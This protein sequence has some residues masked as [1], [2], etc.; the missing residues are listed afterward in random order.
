MDENNQNDKT[1]LTLKLL[2]IG[3]SR[4]GKTSLL[5]NYVEKIFPEAHISTLGV[6]YKEKEIIKDNYVI[7]LQIWDTAGEERF[8]SITK[9]IYRNANGILFVCDITNRE[10]FKNI[11]NWIKDADNVD[12]DIKGIIIGNKIDLDNERVVSVEDLE[13][14]EKKYNMPFIETSAKTGM[15]VNKC[16]EVLID[17]LFKNKNADEIKE[18]YLRKNKND[19]SISTKKTNVKEKG[20]CC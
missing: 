4:V 17:E 19:L 2:I 1:L 16:F 10:S 3:D 18:E 20:G 12:K 15:N 7:R 8:R 14:I 13:E 11:K 6:E 9:S 5:L